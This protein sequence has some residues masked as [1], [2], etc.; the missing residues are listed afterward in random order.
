[1]EFLNTIASP[2]SLDLLV[3]GLVLLF[4]AGARFS[5]WPDSAR[6]RFF[7]NPREYIDRARYATFY[8]LYQVSFLILVFIILIFG[9]EW[10]FGIFHARL[11]D[12]AFSQ[13]FGQAS[14]T[15]SALIAIALLDAPKFR[16]GDE[17]WRER[18]QQWA[19]IPAAVGNMSEQIRNSPGAFRPLRSRVDAI[20]NEFQ[21]GSDQEFWRVAHSNLGEEKSRNSAAWLCF[22]AHYLLQIVKEVS[23]FVNIKDL[24]EIEARMFRIR[25]ELPRQ[26][27]RLDS[28]SDN[29]LRDIVEVEEQLREEFCKYVVRNHKSIAEQYRVLSNY[30]FCLDLQEAQGLNILKPAFYSIVFIVFACFG[31]VA[32]YLGGTELAILAEVNGFSVEG[33]RFTSSAWLSWSLG[34]AFCIVASIIVAFFIDAALNSSRKKPEPWIYIIALG[35]SV[36]ASWVYFDIVAIGEAD[37]ISRQWAFFSL[38]LTFSLLSVVA[39]KSLYSE[40]CIDK[41]RLKRSSLRL[42]LLVFFVAGFLQVT[43]K[44]GFGGGFA[45]LSMETVPGLVWA[46]LFGGVRAG[47]IA[48]FVS[49][50]VQNHFRKQLLVRQRD[51]PRVGHRELV[52]TV[53][54]SS[55]DNALVTDLSRTGASMRADNVEAGREI[56]IRFGFGMVHGLVQ[57][58][59]KGKCGVRFDESDTGIAALYH[60]IK[61]KYGP[62][63][64]VPEQKDFMTF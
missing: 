22:R 55:E 6:H 11:P 46:F 63:Y 1:M 26:L 16:Q 15:Y 54:G 7:G 34:S 23:A 3:L 39:L 49:F 38:A 9:H 37:T 13:A 52:S 50:A 57:W 20:F 10:L 31:S 33:P 2:A 45:T 42:G 59:S 19:R 43:A 60:F 61:N 44:M 56:A 41:A 21:C 8:A 5:R 29:N 48:Y 27:A 64:A 18:L 53:I 32:L 17:H 40:H 47:L 24:K 14:F 4:V 28:G 25:S 58:S 35:A 30:G 51:A 62:F 36:L 12:S